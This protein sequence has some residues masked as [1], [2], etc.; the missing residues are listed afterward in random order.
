MPYYT[1]AQ[2]AGVRGRMAE[3]PFLPM[4]IGKKSSYTLN[5]CYSLAG[6]RIYD[7]TAAGDEETTHGCCTRL[8]LLPLS[9]AALLVA[10]PAA[11]GVVVN[12]PIRCIVRAILLQC[13][14]AI[15]CPDMRK[16]RQHT[17]QL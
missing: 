12:A 7:V 8:L 13:G 15:A 1:A 3:E 14:C 2:D 9:V 11:I 5:A 4:R 6:K 16:V 10:A 17:R